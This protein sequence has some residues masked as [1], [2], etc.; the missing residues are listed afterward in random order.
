MKPLN[1]RLK[2]ELED[3]LSKYERADKWD[4]ESNLG[5][6]LWDKAKEILEKNMEKKISG[7][8]GYFN[9]GVLNIEF[10]REEDGK[11]ERWFNRFRGDR[12]KVEIQEALVEALVEPIDYRLSLLDGES[13]EPI[14]VPG[15]D[16]GPVP[17]DPK[18]D[19]LLD[20]YCSTPTTE[21][22]KHSGDLEWVW[23]ARIASKV[24]HLVT[25][26]PKCGKS[27]VLFDLCQRV[28][29]GKGFP[30]GAPIPE[31]L[32]GKKALWI[33]ADGRPDYFATLARDYGISLD[34]HASLTFPNGLGQ[35]VT[36]YSDGEGAPMM[37]ERAFRSGDYW[38]LVVDTL[39]RYQ[40]DVEINTPQG[41]NRVVK[42]L[43]ELA[44][45][46]NIPVFL[47]GHTNASGDA[48]GSHIRGACQIAWNLKI[49]GPTKRA[50]FC[51]RSFAAPFAPLEFN[52]DSTPLGWSDI[53]P[54]APR[55]PKGG[56]VAQ[57]AEEWIIEAL[58]AKGEAVGGNG[59]PRPNSWKE[60]QGSA[61]ESGISRN[62]FD[63]AIKSLVERGE[64]L[65]TKTPGARGKFVSRFCLPTSPNG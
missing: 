18:F 36:T 59:G 43:Q 7:A 40:G 4:H 19:H 6:E 9:D 44:R 11:S 46:L 51:D 10:A 29:Y 49:K 42:P 55:K 13:M 34:F 28:F 54:E 21:I 27:T 5:R 65:E 23:P 15:H 30:D 2:R 45:R 39:S 17:W 41:V 1:E 33:D 47:L 62:T 57:G 60:L 31:R 26:E 22:I 20:R 61:L 24:T 37:A 25:G 52:F 48:Y 35:L 12:G 8:L 16:P 32:V 58:R 14:D 3:R 56:K 53:C 50:L 63:R 64:V 38:C